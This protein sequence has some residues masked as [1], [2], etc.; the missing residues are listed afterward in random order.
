[1]SPELLFETVFFQERGLSGYDGSYAAL[2]KQLSGTWI[3]FDKKAHQ[4][5]EQYKLSQYL[6]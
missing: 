4:K 3:T 5:I 6:G 2:A 1:M